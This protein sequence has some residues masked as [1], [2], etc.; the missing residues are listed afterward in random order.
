MWKFLVLMPYDPKQ[1]IVVTC[2]GSNYSIGY[3]IA[4]VLPDSSERPIAFA[5][6]TLTK[7][8]TKYSQIEKEALA[9]MYTIKIPQFF[10]W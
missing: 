8:E 1:E 4:H 2:N 5:S 3:V 9:I 6:K 10:V 7:Y